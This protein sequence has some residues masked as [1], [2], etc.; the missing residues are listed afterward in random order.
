MRMG[1]STAPNSNDPLLLRPADA[2]YVYLPG[3]AGNYLSVPDEAALRVTG[4]LDARA[5]FRPGLAWTA[6]SSDNG[7]V[8]RYGTVAA[9]SFSFYSGYNSVPGQLILT[10]YDDAGATFNAYSTAAPNY[11]AET[12]LWVRATLDLDNGAGKYEV[13]FF[14]S[15]DG[16]AWVQLGNTVTGAATTT[17]RA[18]T[19][20]AEVGSRVNGAWS[21]ALGKVLRAQIFNG[22]DGTMVL[23]VDC[24][25]ITDGS[26]TSFLARTGQLVTINRATT[27]RKA[28]A[29][30]SKHLAPAPHLG[31]NMLYV[32]QASFEG[33][34]FGTHRSNFGSSATRAYST[35]HPA[36]GSMCYSV[37]QAADG[38]CG[39]T[40]VNPG[41]GDG[42]F[43]V[44]AGQPYTF[45]SQM[46]STVAGRPNQYEIVWYNAS[47]G[48]I[49]TFWP[50]NTPTA[51][52]WGEFVHQRTAPDSA[53]SVKWSV[54]TNGLTG[55]THYW[56]CLGLWPGASTDWEMPSDPVSPGRP[57]LLFGTDDYLECQGDEQH[58][59]L[60]VVRH[61]G[62]TVV[63]L[64]RAWPTINNKIWMTKL[65]SSFGTTWEQ[66]LQNSGTST[67]TMFYL[68]GAGQGAIYTAAPHP[69]WGP[70]QALYGTYIPN[71]AV[72]VRVITNGGRSTGLSRVDDLQF[73]TNR[74]KQAISQPASP[75]DME[76]FAA[77]IFRRALTDREIA[78]ITAYYGAS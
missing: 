5:L 50:T 53:V 43:P 18:G 73:K 19:S 25:A 22:I 36:F 9:R 24:D 11:P 54:Y 29:M 26:Q 46:W 67:R 60:N 40:L 68:G 57:L 10:W 74:A 49:S 12:Q 47:G 76:F 27:G 41:A 33:P 69:G 44:V 37:T 71:S 42:R 55:E 3:I 58:K 28:V 8:A 38:N 70:L 52:A 16:S 66:T 31:K 7:F 17:L 39:F 75:A 45:Y 35:D 14:T 21:P 23:D 78:L 48:A 72:P 64:M 15:L 4:D 77:A 30:P 63:L 20:A 32:E 13:K 6:T 51:G 34:L 61:Q 1:S 2:G 65:D 62:Y 56:D 59:W